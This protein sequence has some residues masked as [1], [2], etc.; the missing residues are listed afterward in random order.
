MNKTWEDIKIIQIDAFEDVTALIM[1]LALLRDNNPKYE[2]FRLRGHGTYETFQGLRDM[3]EEEIAI[4]N[5]KTKHP[6]YLT[7]LRLKEIFE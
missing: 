2:N 4:A 1:Y 6:E 3:T 5:D 7:Y